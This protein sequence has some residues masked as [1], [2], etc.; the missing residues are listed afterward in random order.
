[1]FSG[2]VTDSKMTRN[3]RACWWS[4]SLCFQ[5]WLLTKNLRLAAQKWKRS[6]SL[7]FQGWL[8][9]SQQARKGITGEVSIPLFS[10]LVTDKKVFATSTRPTSQ[11]LC[12]QGWLLTSTPVAHNASSD[13]SIPLFSGLV[14]DDVSRRF[15]VQRR[16]LNPFVFRAGY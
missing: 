13:V 1:M 12:F 6:Q 16:R 2:L 4:Q 5:G 10:G 8:L 3:Q 15:R 11:S 14:T 9:T 7:C